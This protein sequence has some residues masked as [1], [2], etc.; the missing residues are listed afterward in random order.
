MIYETD[1]IMDEKKN[2]AN[3]I[4]LEKRKKKNR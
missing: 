1:R 3:S 4:I 2:I